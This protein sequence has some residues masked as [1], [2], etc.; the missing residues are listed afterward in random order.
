MDTSLQAYGVVEIGGADVFGGEFLP[1][2]PGLWKVAGALAGALLTA[3]IVQWDDF[4]DG[5]FAGYN[6]AT[7]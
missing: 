7:H 3:I 2:G 5:V 6:A 4:K 1:I